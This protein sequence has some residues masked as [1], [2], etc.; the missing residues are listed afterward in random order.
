MIV[1]P[2]IVFQT[3]F[4]EP[5]ICDFKNVAELKR[6]FQFCFNFMRPHEKTTL[7][8]GLPEFRLGTRYSFSFDGYYYESDI[9][10]GPRFIVAKN[11]IHDSDGRIFANIP[12][13]APTNSS[14]SDELVYREFRSVQITPRMANATIDINT[15]RQ[16]WPICE[17]NRSEFARF[18]TFL[19]RQK[20]DIKS[21]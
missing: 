17:E 9:K 11:I 7:Q 20:I 10:W 6:F 5:H 19:G 8:T 15:H 16:L 21:R 13:D 1:R 12:V 18:L 3:P 2:N 14:E 4:Y